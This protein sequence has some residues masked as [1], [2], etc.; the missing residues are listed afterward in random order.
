MEWS[1]LIPQ[2]P[3]GYP[4]LLLTWNSV[5]VDSS[6]L[7][8]NFSALPF[9]LCPAMRAHHSFL[10]L[11]KGQCVCQALIY[12]PVSHGGVS[13]Q[14]C[15]RLLPSPSSACYLLTPVLNEL[16]GKTTQHFVHTV[17]TVS[18]HRVG[19]GACVFNCFLLVCS[20]LLFGVVLPLWSCDPAD[21][22]SSCLA[23]CGH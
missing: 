8:L 1:L 10:K 4:E 22:P 15:S 19:T 17:Q 3:M 20:G 13:R 5:Y 11:H 16:L 6:G 2:R 18:C 12:P 23:F 9:F 14:S 7:L 21:S